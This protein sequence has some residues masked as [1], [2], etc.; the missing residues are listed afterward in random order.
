[1]TTGDLDNGILPIPSGFSQWPLYFPLHF[2]SVF[3]VTYILY[4]QI[5]NVN[6][7]ILDFCGWHLD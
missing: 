1:M 3:N 2:S 4:S 7:L 5:I 6:I